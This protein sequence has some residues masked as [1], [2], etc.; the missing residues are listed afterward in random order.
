MERE[1]VKRSWCSWSTWLKCTECNFFCS[2]TA[3]LV[4]RG[5]CRVRI[6]LLMFITPEDLF[7]SG[8]VYWWVQRSE[9]FIVGCLCTVMF[10]AAWSW[11]GNVLSFINLSLQRG[12]R[13]KVERKL[14]SL[15]IT[16]VDLNWN[17]HT[18]TP[19]VCDVA[20]ELFRHMY[21]K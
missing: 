11:R 14:E 4:E 16:E 20:C 9:I 21:N 8:A 15:V 2:P 19:S 7:W 3:T 12:E 13:A 6:W 17:S 5:C 10:T 18:R 1:L